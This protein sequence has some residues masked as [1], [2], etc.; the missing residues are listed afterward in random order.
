MPRTSLAGIVRAF[1]VEPAAIAL[2]GRRVN[3]HWRVRARDG[4]VWFLR[5]FGEQPDLP[6]DAA[7]ELE[8]VRALASRGWPVAA[9]VTEPRAFDGRLYV[10]L[11]HLAGRALAKG[12]VG[13][14]GYVWLGRRL[15][16]LHLLLGGLA[17]PP[18][19][20]DW[21]ELLAGSRPRPSHPPREELLAFLAGHAPALADR[22]AAATEAFEA[23]DLAAVFAGAPRQIVHGDF[24]PW[25]VLTRGARLTGVLDFELAHVDVAA[26]DLAFARR[27]SHDGV[28][29]GYLEVRPLPDAHIAALDA[30]WTGAVLTSAWL[31]LAPA[32]KAGRLDPGALDWPAAQLDKTYPYSGSISA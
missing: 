5:R 1:G 8:A 9:A 3:T 20:P 27:G 22:L 4:S 32:L 30:L 10:L 14:D 2:K 31:E 15:A 16:E 18:Q 24:S 13:E 29:R 7:W 23:R 25:N 17:P 26:A 6:A 11:P 28:V 12:P 19:R 21:A